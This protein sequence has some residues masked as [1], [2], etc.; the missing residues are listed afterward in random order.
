[1]A[2]GWPIN[3]PSSAVMGSISMDAKDCHYWSQ[4]QTIRWHGDPRGLTLPVSKRQE[5]PSRNSTF[6]QRTRQ[7]AF[8]QGVYGNGSERIIAPRESN[9]VP[10]VSRNAGCPSRSRAETSKVIIGSLNNCHR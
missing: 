10:H 3:S 5:R 8:P 2:T 6:L 4:R 1:M 7:S 9:G